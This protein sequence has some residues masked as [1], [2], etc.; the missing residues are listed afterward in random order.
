MTTYSITVNQSGPCA[1]NAA[2]ANALAIFLSSLAPE[3]HASVSLTTCDALGRADF[4]CGSN[5]GAIGVVDDV[6]R[7]EINGSGSG[8]LDNLDAVF[9]FIRRAWVS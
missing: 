9:A 6:I 5:T 3:A 1:L 7:V 2:G 8:P 4:A